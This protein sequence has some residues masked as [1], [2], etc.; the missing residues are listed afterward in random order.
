MKDKINIEITSMWLHIFAMITM[1]CDHLWATVIP[2]NDWLTRLGRL[3]FPVFAFTTVEGYFK[4][5][6]L[7][8][9][10]QRMLIFALISE[11]PFNLIMGSSFIYPLHQNVLW[12]F[13]ISIG[14]MYL[15]EKTK[16][17]KIIFL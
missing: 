8:K 6:N 14:L 5:N 11:I 7:K 12:T 15:L 4:T 17:K 10:V 16:Q 9:Y 1:L 2:G 13:L 3:A